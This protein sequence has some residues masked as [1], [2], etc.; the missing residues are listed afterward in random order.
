MSANSNGTP[1]MT[2]Q[3]VRLPAFTKQCW[4]SFDKVKD[5]STFFSNNLIISP[6][7]DQH[8]CDCKLLRATGN[9]IPFA[10]MIT[11]SRCHVTWTSDMVWF[12]VF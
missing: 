3:Y 10:A 7:H 5:S 9:G 6:T 4:F 1:S 8:L 2:I 12:L 11:E